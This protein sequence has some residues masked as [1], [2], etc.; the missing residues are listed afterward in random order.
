[1]RF[2]FANLRGGR[3]TKAAEEDD[4]DEVAETEE[5]EEA[6]EEEDAETSAEGDADEEEDA[7]EKAARRR[8]V[9]QG[10]K[11]ERA[12]CAAIFAAAG[13]NTIEMAANLAFN[14]GLSSNEAKAVLDA[15]PQS[16]GGLGARMNGRDPAPAAAGGGGDASDDDKAAQRIL[17]RRKRDKAA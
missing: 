4:A 2:N 17:S 11:A 16:G 7:A 13:P 10:R 5:E 9:A 6:V 1:M 15:A 3:K 14:T 8:G 12:R